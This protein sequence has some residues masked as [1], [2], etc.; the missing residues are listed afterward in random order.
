MLFAYYVNHFNNYTA[1][2]GS[3]GGIIILLIWLYLSGMII[4][5][6]GEINAIFYD[7]RVKSS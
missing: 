4:V 6:G 2:Y 3:L 1:T 7:R 5:I